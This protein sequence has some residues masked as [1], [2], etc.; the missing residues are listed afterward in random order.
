[1]MVAAQRI[2]NDKE[3]KSESYQS[4]E[5]AVKKIAARKESEVKRY[6]KLYGVNC[7]DLTNYNLLVDTSFLT[8]QEVADIILRKFEIWQGDNNR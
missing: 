7:L 8:P 2:F 4:C 5:D 6:Q 1:M 3:R